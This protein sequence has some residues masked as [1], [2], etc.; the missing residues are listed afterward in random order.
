MAFDPDKYLATN[1][2]SGSFDP[3]AYL[4]RPLTQI[5]PGIKSPVSDST[6]ENL[7]AGVG[8][9]MTGL[10]KGVGQRLG[11][12]PSPEEVDKT[13]RLEKPLMETFSGKAGN[14]GGNVA[15]TLP[16]LAIPGMQSFPGA[17][18]MGI[19]MGASQPVGS[20]DSVMKNIAIG[21]GSAVAGQFLGDKVASALATRLAKK[22]AEGA[23]A[24]GK[25]SLKDAVLKQSQEVGYA[26]PKSE[27]SP[28]FLNNR[29]ESIAGKAALKQ[30]AALRNQQ[31]SNALGGKV[32]GLSDDQPLSVTAI[33]EF[34]KKA[35]EPYRQVAA[36]DNRAAVALEALKSVRNKAQSYWNHYNRTADPESLAIA[37]ALNEKS[38]M[39]ETVIDKVAKSKGN[40]QLLSALRDSRRM[41]AQSYDLQR[42]TN[43]TTGD[44]SAAVLGRMLAKGKP[45]SGELKTIAE[46]NRAFPKFSGNAVSTPAAGV[47]K[48]EAMASVL[49]GGGGAAALGPAGIAAGALPL[50]STPVRN[51][52]LSKTYQQALVNPQAYGPSNTAKVI[53]AIANNPQLQRL[54]PSG[55]ASLGVVNAE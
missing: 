4:R 23:A 21:E 54:I 16:A 3:D 46:F 38:D 26:V 24:Q 15:A 10:V 40:D 49:L 41:I 28:S 5:D 42:A 30:D 17:Q 44:V 39:L 53:T 51:A 35:A 19:A 7:A 47:G 13:R 9:G 12:G 22:T 20:K 50:M 52:L 32:I 14:I 36:L 45:L 43:E 37:K 34:R 1:T 55:A 48:T 18:L 25:N 29:L 27:V 31:V 8:A 2:Q 6:L 33:E 11:I